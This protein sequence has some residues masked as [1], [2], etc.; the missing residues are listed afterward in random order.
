MVQT[1]DYEAQFVESDLSNLNEFASENEVGETKISV[2]DLDQNHANDEAWLYLKN[3][4]SEGLENAYFESTID[5]D[6]SIDLASSYL[7]LEE[8]EEETIDSLIASTD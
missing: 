2:T 4:S 3:P 8:D 7:L 5:A 6:L 1:S